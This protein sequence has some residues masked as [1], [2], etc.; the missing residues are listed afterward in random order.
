VK[1][2]IYI[3]SSTVTG[4]RI[5]NAVEKANK[6]APDWMKKLVAKRQ[7]GL[8][9]DFKFCNCKVVAVKVGVKYSGGLEVDF[10]DRLR[11]RE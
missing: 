3:D 6:E 5:K 2:R 8:R 11:Y 1:R 7:K 4:K 9:E 10:S